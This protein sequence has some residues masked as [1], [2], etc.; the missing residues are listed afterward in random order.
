MAADIPSI[1]PA[2]FVAGETVSWTKDVST[3][4]PAND[5]W[6]LTYYLRGDPSL[7]IDQAATA[8]GAE[9][10]VTI[11]AAQT[12]ALVAGLRRLIGRV[13][14]AGEIYTI[15]DGSVEVIANPVSQN[16][17]DETRSQWRRIRD[18]LRDVIEGKAS[19]DSISYSIAGRSVSRM[20]WTE[21]LAAYQFAQAEVRAEEADESIARGETLKKNIGIRFRRP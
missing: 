21:L 4:Y 20:S 16:I 12:A 8:S 1:E 17:G 5:G 15:Y 11:T 13:S 14:K 10:A 6:S 7:N 2:S 3:N 19:K 9:F 18:E